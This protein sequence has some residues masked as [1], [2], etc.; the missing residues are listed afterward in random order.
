MLLHNSLQRNGIATRLLEYICQDAAA[1]GFNFVE[2]QAHKE[3]A[4]DGFRGVLA[5]YEKCGVVV[6]AEKNGKIVVQKCL[7]TNRS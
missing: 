7:K 1:C 3:F 6:H 4:D 2:A 5:M